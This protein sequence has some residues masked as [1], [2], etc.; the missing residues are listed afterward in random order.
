MKMH[1]T[2]L[3][4][5]LLLTLAACAAPVSDY[6]SSEAVN[7]LTLNDASHSFVVRFIPGSDRLAYGEAAR[8]GRMVATGAI[9]ASDRLSV[10]PAGSPALAERR[11]VTLSSEM[12]R[13]GMTISP[14][15]VA[16]VPRD[17]AIVEVGRYVVTLPPC[18][19]WSAP[20]AADFSNMRSSNFG[21]A[22]VTNLGEMI[23]NP[24]DLASGQPVGLAA[25]MPAA[26]AVYRYKNDKVILPT[27]NSSLPIAAPSTAAPG[28]GN[29]PGS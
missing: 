11:V 7:Q 28:G 27:P 9:T 12:L 10:S 23:A 17:S 25:G 14:V 5:A 6:T 29:S 26:A 20:A 24:S 21:C 19:N 13:H 8:L 22:T 15:A 16:D 1:P 18:P 4:A 3:A 2:L